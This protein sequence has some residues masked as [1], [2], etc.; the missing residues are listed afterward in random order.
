MS[1]WEKE[2]LSS[3]R[4]YTKLPGG[5][6]NTS[7]EQLVNPEGLERFLKN[8]S[9]KIGSEDRKAQSSLLVKRYAFLA[10]ISLFTFSAFN[11]KLNVSPANVFLAD[12]NKN[13]LWMPGFWLVDD[14][15]QSVKDREKEREEA[16]REVFLDHLF[17][18]ID[19]V[20]ISTGLSD[21]ISW[22]NVAV[23][24]FWIYEGLIEHEDLQ[25]ARSRMEE[26]FRWL[27]DDSNAGLFGPYKKNPL[28]RYH[29]E[30]QYVREQDSDLRVRLTCCFSYKLRG[31]EGNRCKTCPQT[32]NVKYPKGVR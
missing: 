12:G 13:G 15:A 14:S 26:D 30:K 6:E 19:S 21:L 16:A 5:R 24:M 3:F 2:W 1:D 28:A 20:K 17:P 25:H 11:K 29:S 9:G 32:C 18:L 7:A 31:G 10:V 27:L 8:Y 4:L 22:E 23:Y